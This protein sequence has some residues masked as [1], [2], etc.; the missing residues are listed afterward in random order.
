MTHATPSR[1]QFLSGTATG[2]AALALGPAA[3]SAEGN[4]DTEF[5]Y[6]VT[7]SEEEWKAMLSEKEYRIL[8]KGSTEL[9]KSSDLWNETRN[10]L[11]CCRGCSLSLYEARNKVE[12]DKGWAFFQHSVPN[13]VLTGIDG[14]QQEY[15]QMADDLITLIEAHCRRCGS[16]LGHIL[17]VERQV[18]HCIN[19]TSLEFVPKEA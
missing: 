4:A 6:E 17:K 13:S 15:G 16:H 14:P 2:A 8:R 7:R 19:G 3:A 10:G 18:L 12:L 11:F 5:T 9:P 1:R